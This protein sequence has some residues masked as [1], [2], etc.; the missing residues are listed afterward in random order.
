MAGTR[1]MDPLDPA[2]VALDRLGAPLERYGVP[3][4]PGSLL[5]LAR[6][7]D[8]AGRRHAGLRAVLASDDVRSGVSAAAG[9]PGGLTRVARRPRPRRA[10]HEGFGVPVSAIPRG[11][12]RE[13]RSSD[14]VTSASIAGSTVRPD[15]ADGAR[16]GRSL[17]SARSS[18]RATLSQLLVCPCRESSTR[19]GQS[20][21]SA[22]SA[23]SG[24]TFEPDG[25]PTV[26]A[27]MPDLYSDVVLEH[28]RR[29]RNRGGCPTPTRPRRR[30]IHSAVTSS[31][32]RSR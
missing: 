15:A 20:V 29:P 9:G 2:F 18:P 31:D 6:L 4:H 28:Y 22:P 8:H 17:L 7:G 1:A 10:A 30:P 27:P 13:V 24:R 12:A 25:S 26:S 23:A 21:R 32:S 19:Q 16:S 14:A 5:W 11:W 3:A